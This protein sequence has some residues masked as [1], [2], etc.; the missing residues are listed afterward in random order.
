MGGRER[1][2]I[3]CIRLQR[4]E[5][6]ECILQWIRERER[7]RGANSLKRERNG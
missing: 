5:E 2:Q 1:V 6:R 4:L 7:E 3:I